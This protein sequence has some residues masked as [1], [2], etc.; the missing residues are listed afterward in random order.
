MQQKPGSPSSGHG[1]NAGGIRPEMSSRLV[2]DRKVFAAQE[3][4]LLKTKICTLWEQGVCRRRNCRFAHGEHELRKQ[5][6]FELTVMCRLQGSCT[7]P[8]CRYAHS[9]EELRPRAKSPEEPAS[10]PPT[11]GDQGATPDTAF[12]AYDDVV[13]HRST[14]PSSVACAASPMVN[15]EGIDCNGF[16]RQASTF[17][18]QTTAIPDAVPFSRQTTEVFEGFGLSRQTTGMSRQTTAHADASTWGGFSRQC[19]AVNDGSELRGV[20]KQAFHAEC[21]DMHGNLMMPPVV[22]NGLELRG[23]GRQVS[24]S[25]TQSAAERS[26][27]AGGNS[28]SSPS[29]HEMQAGDV[30]KGGVAVNPSLQ[31]T[32]HGDGTTTLESA[33]VDST[34]GVVVGT[35]VSER[36]CLDHDPSGSI[37]CAVC[38]ASPTAEPAARAQI[39][40]QDSQQLR[41]M[42]MMLPPT[43]PQNLP[44]LPVFEQRGS[45]NTQCDATF[46]AQAMTQQI[47][48]EQY[49]RLLEAAMPDRYED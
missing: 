23:F 6:S 20:N 24:G 44:W 37:D 17:S 22:R 49:A 45:A 7:D 1:G 34:K 4:L 11:E 10:D 19:S 15:S 9:V 33:A 3:H 42:V 8:D 26:P 36:V 5:P 14:S 47:L 29:K 18:R 30:G 21:A 40:F 16:L 12:A 43:F 2:R 25:T 13:G 27:M 48:R 46:I 31:P 41:A 39:P 32:G 35:H 38:D 28:S